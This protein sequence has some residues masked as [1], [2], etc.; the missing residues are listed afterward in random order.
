MVELRNYL[1]ANDGYKLCDQP[2]SHELKN[3]ERNVLCMHNKTLFSS[4]ENETLPFGIVVVLPF[5]FLLGIVGSAGFYE[6]G[7]WS[8]RGE[9]QGQSQTW[10]KRTEE[11]SL[12][13][14]VH[15]EPLMLWKIHKS[16]SL[17]VQGGIKCIECD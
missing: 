6:E 1:A 2:K 3:G 15:Q 9:S 13:H 17:R 7:T 4:K 5:G 10:W 8:D 16:K 11:E 12:K 14:T